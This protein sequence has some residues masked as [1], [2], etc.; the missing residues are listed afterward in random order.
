MKPPKIVDIVI[1]FYNEEK[2][3]HLLFEQLS[4]VFLELNNLQWKAHLICVNDGSEDATLSALKEHLNKPLK[5]QFFYTI[6]DL[7]RNFGHQIAIRAGIRQSV[8]ECLI[9]LDA[10]LQDPPNLFPKMIKQYQKG[11]DIIHMVRTSRKGENFY[12]KWAAN[13]FYKISFQ[14]TEIKT[15]PQSAD[16]R[17]ISRRIVD[18]INQISDPNLTLRGLIPW[19]GYKQVVLEFNRETRIQG[20]SKYTFKKLFNLAK[21]CILGF[22]IAPL[23]FASI[24]GVVFLLFSLFFMFFIFYALF[25]QIFVPFWAYLTCLVIFVGGIQVFCIGILGEYV[26]RIAEKSNSRPIFLTNELISNIE[27]NLKIETNSQV[28]NFKISSKTEV[29]NSF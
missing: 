25:A 19:L 22:S 21:D 13:I 5:A 7:S 12:K 10:D 17:L 26:G 1:P 9:S 20:E 11:F 28:S 27:Y 29:K 23:R 14:L 4:K 2:L 6:V 3:I 16:F 24:V 18:I 15:I 8:G